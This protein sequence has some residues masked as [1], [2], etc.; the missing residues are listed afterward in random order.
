MKSKAERTLRVVG[1]VQREE[2]VSDEVF[3]RSKRLGDCDGPVQSVDDLVTS[4]GAVVLSAFQKA[5]MED[6]E[7]LE[8][9]STRL[10]VQG[11]RR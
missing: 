2:L 10:C 5:C 1:L 4:P 3:A 8:A 7:L 6:L 11:E 9:V